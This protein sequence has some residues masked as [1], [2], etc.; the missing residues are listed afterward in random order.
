MTNLSWLIDGHELS[1]H[2]GI[3]CA[4]AT[5]DSDPSLHCAEAVKLLSW[6]LSRLTVQSRGLTEFYHEPLALL[7]G[8]E[9]Q[10]QVQSCVCRAFCMHG[11]GP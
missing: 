7:V 9:A 10:S 4:A 2:R 6:H 3:L 8:S 5:R 1:R 11:A